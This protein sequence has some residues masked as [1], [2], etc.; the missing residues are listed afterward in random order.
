[1]KRYIEYAALAAICIMALGTTTECRAWNRMGHESAVLLAQA[2]LTPGVRSRVDAILGSSMKSNA[3]WLDD[4]GSNKEVGGYTRKWHD[5]HLDAELVPVAANDNDALVQI[6]R[7]ADV[8][9]HRADH[10]DSLVAASLRTL[11]CLVPE[12]HSIPHVRIANIPL[13]KKKFN[14]QL[15]N[16][17]TGKKAAITKTT[18]EKFWDK[19]VIFNQHGAFSPEMYAADMEI[20]YG[21]DAAAFAAGTPRDWASEMGREC[22]VLYKWAAEDYML[23]REFRNRQEPI[24]YKC[25]ARSGYRL[26]ALLN[27]CLK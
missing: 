24:A 2:R 20:C 25:L 3:G 7:A 27:E 4:F 5:L 10:P 1:M 18:W 16:G 15:S 9:R 26:A 13:S 11:L 14:V 12:M 19:V 22:A 21:A 6:E 17:F 8:L 23:S